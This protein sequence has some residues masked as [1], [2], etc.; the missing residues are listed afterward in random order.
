ME[1]PNSTAVFKVN[2]AAAQIVGG[3]TKDVE[4]S[5]PAQQLTKA[6]PDKYEDP[7]L[8]VDDMLHYMP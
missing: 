8:D 5:P 3:D 4:I 2:V 1:A 7:P 6:E